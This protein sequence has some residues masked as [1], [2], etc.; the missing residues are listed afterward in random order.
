[1]AIPLREGLSTMDGK[2]PAQTNDEPHKPADFGPAA[3]KAAV[4]FLIQQLAQPQGNP[5]FKIEL[6]IKKSRRG[7]LGG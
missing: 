2:P 1:L 3:A 7:E 5:S 6:E 4:D